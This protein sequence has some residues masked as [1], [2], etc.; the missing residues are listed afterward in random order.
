MFTLTSCYDFDPLPDRI[1]SDYEFAIPIIDTTIRVGDFIDF[2]NFSYPDEI[3][4]TLTLP[5]ETPI[6]MGEY[7]YPFYIGDHSSQEIKW[8]EPQIII[9]AKNFPAGT[10]ANIRIY[11]KDDNKEKTYFWLPEN[12]SI[13]LVNTSVRVPETPT[14]IEEIDPFRT[15]R[16]V[17]LDIFFTYLDKVFVSQIKDNQVNIKFGIRFAIKTDLTIKL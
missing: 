1:K 15:V 9:A 4:D 16:K 6:R 7:S 11:T 2:V 13:S 10:I 3:L 5:K 17:Y 12:H 8:L 14:V